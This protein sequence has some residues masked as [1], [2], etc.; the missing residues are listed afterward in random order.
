[1]HLFTN[2][3]SITEAK[4]TQAQISVIVFCYQDTDKDTGEDTVTQTH[5]FPHT[6]YTWE[7][8]YLCI[9]MYVCMYM[10]HKRLLLIIKIHLLT[11]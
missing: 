1:V 4:T 7:Y 10:E 2:R 5:I 3:N 9:C 8:V 11:K 6:H